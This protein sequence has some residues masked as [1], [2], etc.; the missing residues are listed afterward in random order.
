MGQPRR[1]RAGDLAT[2]P[3]RRAAGCVGGRARSQRG[4]PLS[5]L[6]AVV[7]ITGHTGFAG[8]HLADL[9]RHAGDE[10]IGAARATGVDLLDGDALRRTVAHAR[11]SVVYHLAARAQVGRS[12]REPAATLHENVA[13]TLNLLE[14]VRLEAADAAVVSVSSGEVYGVPDRLPADEST[15]LRPQSPYA[16]SKASADLLCGFYADAHGLRVTRA[17]AFN[18]AGPGQPPHHA[19]ASLA[20]QLADGLEA[21]VERPRIVTGSPQVRRDYTDVRDVVRA[22]RRLAAAPPGVYNVCSGRTVATRELVD[23]LGRLAGTP[24]EHV[25]DPELVRPHEVLEI[26]GSATRLERAAGWRPELPLEQTLADT[27]EW[28]RG[29]LRAGRAPAHRHE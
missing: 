27:V 9:C 13:M 11:P 28:W 24:V 1:L 19:V 8:R 21:G 10:V 25:V 2:R 7:L 6:A 3:L 26:S 14:A 4:S 20:L 29:E 15:P 5:P 17:R 16:V 12:W 22:Y 18:H 23:A